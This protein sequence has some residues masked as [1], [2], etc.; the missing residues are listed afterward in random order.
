MEKEVKSKQL[1]TFYFCCLYLYRMFS[2]VCHCMISLPHMGHSWCCYRILYASIFLFRSLNPVNTPDSICIIYFVVFTTFLSLAIVHFIDIVLE[3][4]ELCEE[5][6][7]WFQKHLHKRQIH[8]YCLI[9]NFIDTKYIAIILHRVSKSL[10]WAHYWYQWNG[11]C[12]RNVVKTI[13]F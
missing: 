9:N 3:V 11:I 6:C 7:Q 4:F 12:I 8:I 13:K 1:I 2:M 5:L 10:P